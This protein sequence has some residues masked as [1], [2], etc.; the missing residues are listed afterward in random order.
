MNSY[1][2]LHGHIRGVDFKIAMAT[3]SKHRTR[4]RLELADNQFL[5]NILFNNSQY[6][7]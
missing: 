4:F 7:C 6:M 1:R 5:L 2:P 3:P